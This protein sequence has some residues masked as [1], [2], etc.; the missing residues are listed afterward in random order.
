MEYRDKVSNDVVHVARYVNTSLCYR[1]LRSNVVI[2][3]NFISSF[4][5]NAPHTLG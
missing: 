4:Q 3:L 2:L 5:S 1:I